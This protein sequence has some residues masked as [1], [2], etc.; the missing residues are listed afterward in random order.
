MNYTKQ[1]I[2][3]VS[4]DLFSKKGYSAVS[5]RDICKYVQIKESSIYYHFKN[6]QA[7]LDELVC[8][9][10]S[11]A[12]QMMNQLEQALAEPMGQGK[13]NFYE[14]VCECFF[15][16]YLMDDF[17]N[18]MMRLLA[19]EQF[20]NEEVRKLYHLWVFDK[21]LEF[22]SKV[23]ALLANIG[24]IKD[25]DS[26]YLAVKYYA[27]IYYYAQRWLLSGDLT[28]EAKT[29]FRLNAYKHIQKF[30]ES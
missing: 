21:P 9:F 28:E 7:I 30:F 11:V 25:K 2:F 5:I 16:E 3:E 1:Q 8:Q 17:C 12:T 10:E 27:P 26:E 29:A 4:L 19:I 15:E 23:F 24:Y 6:K 20:S 14:K 18:K 22:Q 13:G